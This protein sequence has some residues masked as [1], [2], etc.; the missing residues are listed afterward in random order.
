MNRDCIE[1]RVWTEFLIF[2]SAFFGGVKSL[3]HSLRLERCDHYLF[4]F[5]IKLSPR[6]LQGR[7]I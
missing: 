7:R 4:S 3:E 5:R 2:G 6:R 1:F